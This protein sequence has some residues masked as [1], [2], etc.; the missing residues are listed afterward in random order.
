[1]DRFITSQHGLP[2]GH[3]HGAKPPAT[4]QGLKTP[5]HGLDPK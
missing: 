1:M 3:H 2:M 5:Y 4:L